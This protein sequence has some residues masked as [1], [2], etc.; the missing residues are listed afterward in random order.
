MR[1]T[2]RLVSPPR[3]KFGRPTS[4]KKTHVIFVTPPNP[5]PNHR[6]RIC[7]KGARISFPHTRCWMIA[8]PLCNSLIRAPNLVRLDPL[9]SKSPIIERS[10]NLVNVPVGHESIYHF[11]GS[12]L[13]LSE[14]VYTILNKVQRTLFPPALTSAKVSGI[15]RRHGGIPRIKRVSMSKCFMTRS[16]KSLGRE[17]I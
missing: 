11:G 1:K 10:G 14:P 12:R 5:F 2:H 8:P 6:V 3:R 13:V 16:C 17:S 15:L 7:G 9:F 4:R